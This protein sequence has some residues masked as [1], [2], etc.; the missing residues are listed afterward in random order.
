MNS[1][2]VYELSDCAEYRQTLLAQPPRF[3][4]AT[5]IVLMAL[6]VAAVLWAALTQAD[7]VVRA[8]G[9]LRPMIRSEQ[10]PDAAAEESKVSPL[11]GGR[12][13][14]VHVQEGDQVRQG[15]LLIHLNTERLDNDIAKQQQSIQAGEHELVRL[16]QTEAMFRQRFQIAKAKAEAEV[17]QAQEEISRAT[18]RR[19]A[20]IRLAEVTLKTAEDEMRRFRKLAGSQSVAESE[21]VQAEARCSEAEI[22]LQQAKLPVEEGRLLVLQQALQLVDSEHAV[23][24]TELDARRQVRKSEVAAARLELSSLE[25]ERQQSGLRAP[26]DGTVTSLGVTVGDVV[27]AGQLVLS[28]AEQCGFRIDVAVASEDVGQLRAGMAVR[29][30]LDAYDYQKYGSV[31][32]RVVFVSPD[33]EFQTGA[34]TQRPPTYTVKIALDSDNVG[35]GTHLGRLKLGMTGVAEIVTDSETIFSLLVRSLRQSISLG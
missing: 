35:R 32:G 25:W 11:R 6:I 16:D 19:H 22:E 2:T 23:E 33:S 8:Q 10:L 28:M 4:R 12:V 3:V 21:V 29:I 7:L 1:R 15:D 18:Q 27:K 31:T 14:E 17:S 9:R 20:A 24:C 34:A 26:S 30:K 5:M 13:I